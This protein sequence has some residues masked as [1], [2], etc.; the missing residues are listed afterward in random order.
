MAIP[1]GISSVAL[2]LQGAQWNV[3]TG[4]RVCPH[5][6]RVYNRPSLEDARLLNSSSV[7]HS[8]PLGSDAWERKKTPCAFLSPEHAEDPRLEVG[9]A[10]TACTQRGPPRRP[11]S[12][13]SC[14]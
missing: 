8:G 7:E 1:S 6:G 9:P 3:P 12:D 2:A 10:G 4:L 11:S 14:S 13:Y 5:N